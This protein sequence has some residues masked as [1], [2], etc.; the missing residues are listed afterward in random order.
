VYA[1]ESEEER[2]T[3]LEGI[4]RDAPG[5]GRGGSLGFFFGRG[6]CDCAG[7]P[8]GPGIG[9]PFVCGGGTGFPT[10]VTDVVAVVVPFVPRSDSELV[11]STRLTRGF[12]A[13]FGFISS[14][15]WGSVTFRGSGVTGAS[16]GFATGVGRT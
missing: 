10:L 11:E 12:I 8:F 7:K 3:F 9:G 1:D 6:S 14:G 5:L 2:Q 16:F 13:S 4:N 15:I